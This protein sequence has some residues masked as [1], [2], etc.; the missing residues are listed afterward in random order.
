MV[1]AGATSHIVNDINKFES[2]DHK[3][4]PSTHSVELVDGSKCGEMAQKRGTA[5]IHL[6]DSAGKR[7]STLHAFISTRHLLGVK[8][9]QR[10]CG[11]DLRERGQ[12]HSHH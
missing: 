6:L 7:R 12:L 1:D 10:R 11:G 5:V 2:F 9:N 8:S 4:Q 3:F